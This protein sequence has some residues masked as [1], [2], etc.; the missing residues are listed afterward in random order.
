MQNIWQTDCSGRLRRLGMLVSFLMGMAVSLSSFGAKHINY[1]VH[2]KAIQFVDEMVA[3]HQFD[4][5]ALLTIF[6]RTEKQQSILDA[7]SRPAEKTKPWHEYR[8][9]FI[10]ERRVKQGVVFWQAHAELLARAEKEFGVPAAI[11]VAILGVETRYGQNTGSYQV[12]DALA[13]LA[14]DYPKRA[15]F[16]RKELEHLLLLTREQ[17]KDA[18]TLKGSYAGAMG[19]GQF[20]PSSYRAYSVDFDNDGFNDIWH[21]AGDAIGSIANYFRRHG[22]RTGEP[23]A[24][25]ATITA[26]FDGSVINNR[27]K[28]ELSI[29]QLRQRG[30][31][32]T[33]TFADNQLAS[34][35]SFVNK[36]GFSYWLALNNFYVITRYN[37]SHLYAMAVYQLSEKVKA[38]YRKS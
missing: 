30:F 4:R 7:I 22:W 29:A 27:A 13:T 36:D 14:F 3:K 37:H 23:V 31:V 17:N 5:A 10:N 6:S 16:F 28:P 26:D 15:K 11:I 20:M 35:L 24:T 21:N 8:K 38:R 1:A 9:I 18:L 12:M 2:P 32:G 33:E 19:Y 34:A 25:V